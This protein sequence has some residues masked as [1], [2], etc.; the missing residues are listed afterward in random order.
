MSLGFKINICRCFVDVEGAT[1]AISRVVQGQC[2][3]TTATKQG[4]YSLPKCSE[5]RLLNKKVQLFFYLQPLL[6]TFCTNCK[7]KSICKMQYVTCDVCVEWVCFNFLC[8]YGTILTGILW[9]PSS[10]SVVRLGMRALSTA[11]MVRP[12]C[13]QKNARSWVIRFIR[14]RFGVSGC[15]PI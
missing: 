11:N 9:M 13:E 8:F 5:A 10:Q 12:A 2:M 3:D 1:W 4:T 6:N 15:Y 14:L 7:R